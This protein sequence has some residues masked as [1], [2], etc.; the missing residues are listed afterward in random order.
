M[1]NDLGVPQASSG[2]LALKSWELVGLGAG[3][4]RFG[5]WDKPWHTSSKYEVPRWG[6][7][8]AAWELVA[9][10]PMCRAHSTYFLQKELWLSPKQ[11]CK[12]SIENSEFW[13][14]QGGDDEFGFGG[15]GTPV[16]P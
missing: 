11:M 6:Q 1:S 16:V 3:V 7:S 8:M 14:R 12:Y 9:G 5:G 10:M 4:G 15:L 13:A 2:V